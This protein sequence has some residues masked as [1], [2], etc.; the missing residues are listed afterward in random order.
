[1]KKIA[2]ILTV[3]ILVF[4]SLS[5]YAQTLKYMLVNNQG[6]VIFTDLDIASCRAH[7]GT[8]AKDGWACVP[9]Q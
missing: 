1:M 4:L 3:S 6:V 8:R 9:Q 7:L 2:Q 5:G